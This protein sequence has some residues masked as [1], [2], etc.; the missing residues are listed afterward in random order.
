MRQETRARYS[1]GD[2]TLGCGS[3]MDRITRTAAVFGTPNAQHPQ[4]CRHEFEHLADRLADSV[5]CPAV[6]RADVPINV[7]LPILA[8]QMAGKSVTPRCRFA[9]WICPLWSRVAWLGS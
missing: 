6:A 8:W 4:P 1:L 5:E 2:G 7:P 9:A 3:L